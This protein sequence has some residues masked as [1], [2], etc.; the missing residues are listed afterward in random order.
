MNDVD[1]R[2]QLTGCPHIVQLVG[3]CSSP[4]YHAIIMAYFE[5]GDLE[6]MLL[7]ESDHHPLI[8]RWDCR[9]RMGLEIAQ[10]M[11]FL[12]SLQPPIIHRDFKTSNILIDSK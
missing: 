1:I 7:S 5:N 9:M 10:G 12:H 11:E 6:E 3:I 8:N 2:Q 4:G